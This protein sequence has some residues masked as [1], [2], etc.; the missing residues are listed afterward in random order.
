MPFDEDTADLFELWSAELGGL[1]V[2]W[3]LTNV[4]FGAGASAGSPASRDDAALEARS[5]E[6]HKPEG[7]GAGVDAV[8]MIDAAAQHAKGLKALVDS[9]AMSLAP[10]PIARAI[11]EHVAHAVWLLEPGITPEARMARRWMARVAAAHRL[12]WMASARR[13][14]SAQVR[15][16]KKLRESLRNEL[17]QRFPGAEIEWN[18]PAENPLPPWNIA[19]EKYPTFGQQTRLLTKFG[20]HNVAGLYDALSLSSHPNIIAL[21]TAIESTREGNHV[22]LSYRTDTEAWGS[23]IRLASSVVYVAACAVCGYFDGQDNH[24]TDWYDTYRPI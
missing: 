22:R 16:A 2:A 13:A 12:R 24:L 7:T 21:T 6:P 9:R 11:V 4:Q 19:G 3:N 5:P 23:I 10:W 14:P 1:Y 8:Q 15:D 17:L 18:D 20:A